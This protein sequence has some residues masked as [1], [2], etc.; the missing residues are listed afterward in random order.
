MLQWNCKGTALNP[1]NQARLAPRSFGLKLEDGWNFWGT[2]RGRGL[3]HN[4]ATNSRQPQSGL[5]HRNSCNSLYSGQG[6]KPHPK[7]V[8]NPT[9][10]LPLKHAAYHETK[11]PKETHLRSHQRKTHAAKLLHPTAALHLLASA[12]HP[13]ELAELR[14]GLCGLTVNKMHTWV[15]LASC[16]P[17]SP[18]CA[19]C[20]VSRS[21]VPSGN[22][23]ELAAARLSASSG[24]ICSISRKR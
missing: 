2:G 5:L 8:K 20:V 11:Q 14:Q 19:F 15:S 7:D 21:L 24:L 1:D 16:L 12:R 22:G 18:Q 3:T 13:Q 6:R 10:S 23:A 4:V 9:E 17:S